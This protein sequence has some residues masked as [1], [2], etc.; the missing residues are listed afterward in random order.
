MD[1][2]TVRDVPVSGKRV[3]VR[4]D[5]NVPIDANGVITDDSRIRATL[6]TIE[7]LIRQGAKIVLMSHLGRPKGKPSP[8]FSLAPVAQKLSEILGRK[9]KLAPDCIG[10]G[11]EKLVAGLKP[12]EVLLL[13]N[14]RFHAEEEAGDPEFAR[15]LAR[16]GDVLV[17]DA[18]GTA[19]RAHASVTGVTRHLPA[20]A[21]FLLEKEINTLGGLLKNP[22]HPFVAIFGGAK[23]SDKVKLLKNIM[24]RVDRLLIG[25]GMAATFLKARSYNVGDSSVE[26]ESID[27]AHEL[28]EDAKNNGVRIILPLDAVIADRLDDGAE[29]RVVDIKS[30]PAGEKIVDIGPK[31]VELFLGEMERARTV[32]WNGPMGIYEI[33]KF[34]RGT[35][36]IA[37]ALPRL[38]AKTIVGGGSTAEII[39]ALG[40]SGKLT[41][42]STGG[43]ASLQFLGGEEL[44]GVTALQD[45]K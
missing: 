10:P 31:T 44:P 40:L 23:V 12:G 35:E 41:F 18:F 45:R 21:G 42:V 36:S 5:F 32:F 7:Y 19:H 43:G 25:G 6:P 17:N 38:E 15:A 28:L 3:L 14:L 1:K 9:V 34:S 39:D 11:V 24:G 13:E 20:V 30:I 37:R 2:M 29:T 4:V 27:V 16:L 26:M 8:E 33:P 22:E